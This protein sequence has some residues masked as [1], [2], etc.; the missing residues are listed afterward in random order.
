[1]ILRLVI[2]TYRVSSPAGR[3]IFR[4]LN[5]L[6]SLSFTNFCSKIHPN[7]VIIKSTRA[8]FSLLVP[9]KQM[10]KF[11]TK[12][13]ILLIA[14]LQSLWS[15]SKPFIT[16]LKPLISSTTPNLIFHPTL[17]TIPSRSKILLRSCLQNRPTCRKITK[18]AS[19]DPNRRFMPNCV[20]N[21][22]LFVLVLWKEV[23][24]LTYRC[25]KCGAAC[26]SEADAAR[27]CAKGEKCPACNGSGR[28]LVGI[29]LQQE[30]KC[31]RCNGSGVI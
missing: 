28:K 3:V 6:S 24:W 22:L 19:N 18:L 29:V 4:F 25:P 2:I 20:M 1:M 30:C 8:I 17:L 12:L 7:T 15:S 11:M 10:I 13:I 26:S 31:D 23:R 27:H 9:T 5:I 14:L 16:K 21:T